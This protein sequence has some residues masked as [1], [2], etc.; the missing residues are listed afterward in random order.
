MSNKVNVSPTVVEDALRHSTIIQ[1]SEL[2]LNWSLSSLVKGW[3]RLIG[4]DPI[5]P[6]KKWLRLLWM[7][8]HWLCFTFTV[9]INVYT[10]VSFYFNTTHPEFFSTNRPTKTSRWNTW[11]DY[12]NTAI[13]SITVQLYLLLFFPKKWNRLKESLDN[14][15]YQL[16]FSW[17]HTYSQFRSICNV[18]T[19]FIIFL[20]SYKYKIPL[21]CKEDYC[22][23]LLLGWICHLYHAFIRMDFQ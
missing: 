8:H 22:F 9:G 5:A 3:M 20:V 10:V 16:N 13:H 21:S 19:A 15:E 7:F 4:I 23:K 18:S 14:A 12:V 6:K 1:S 17:S 2:D 11:I